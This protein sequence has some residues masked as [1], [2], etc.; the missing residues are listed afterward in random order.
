MVRFTMSAALAAALIAA[1]PAKADDNVGKV[2]GAI[3]QGVL[4]QQQAEQEQALWNGVVKSN[5]VAAYRQ[6]LNTYP[7]GPHAAQARDRLA[8]KGQSVGGGNVGGMTAGMIAAAQRDLG[9]LGYYSGRADGVAGRGTR[10]AIAAWQ[11]AHGLSQT[12]QLTQDQAGRLSNEA[13]GRGSSAGNN[14]DTATGSGGRAAELALGLSRSE[15]AQVQADLN[16]LGY[17]VGSPDGIFG[18]GTR[19]ALARWQVA[20][21]R[22]GTGYLADGEQRLLRNEAAGRGGGAAVDSNSQRNDAMDEQLMDLDRGERIAVQRKLTELGYSTNG[23]DGG[24]GPATRRAIRAWQGDN[25]LKAT[26]Y[27][28][29]DQLAQLRRQNRTG[30]SANQAGALDDA[31]EA[32]LAV[33]ESRLLTDTNTRRLVEQRLSALGLNPGNVDGQFTATTRNAIR[34]YQSAHGQTAT[35]FV[36][37]AMLTAMVG[38]VN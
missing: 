23:T 30:A 18:S 9:S 13:R 35:G 3:A 14:T 12:G 16:T 26:G 33:A 17:N 7:N 4:A 31:E 22:A 20:H 8:A 19:Q 2:I 5:S 36:D 24:F 25:G 27:L 29:A 28:N 37:S 6:Y 1:A 11:A 38:E 15:R 32:R 21:Q 34:R 10:A